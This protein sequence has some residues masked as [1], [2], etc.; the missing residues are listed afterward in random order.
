MGS[1]L[2]WPPIACTNFLLS[3][4]VRLLIGSLP[5]VVPPGQARTETPHCGV[6]D[7]ADRFMTAE[8]QRRVAKPTRVRVGLVFSVPKCAQPNMAVEK[9]YCEV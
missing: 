8:L 4:W 5:V 1:Q 9:S 3:E 6:A 7:Q 2:T